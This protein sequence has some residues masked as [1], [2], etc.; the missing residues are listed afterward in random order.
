MEN[1]V[2]SLFQ[3]F[4]FKVTLY[5]VQCCFTRLL[6]KNAIV[7]KKKQNIKEIMQLK[8]KYN[9]AIYVC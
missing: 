5:L 7:W 6:D 1:T 4:I 8:M 9:K 2:I 3:E